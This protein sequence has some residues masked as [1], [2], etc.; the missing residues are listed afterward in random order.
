MGRERHTFSVGLVQQLSKKTS[1]TFSTTVHIGHLLRDI[2]FES[3]YNG[4]ST[5]FVFLL[6]GILFVC[7]FFSLGL[8][9]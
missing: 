5:L 7:L 2:D 8:I 1:I 3:G 6:D 4:L 9:D